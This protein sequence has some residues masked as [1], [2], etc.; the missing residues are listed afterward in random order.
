M[1]HPTLSSMLTTDLGIAEAIDQIL[2]FC[3]YIL[4]LLEKMRLD[5]SW[6]KWIGGGHTILFWCASPIGHIRCYGENFQFPY[7]DS[8]SP[9]KMGLDASWMKS[10]GEGHPT[11]SPC[12]NTILGIAAAT[13]RIR[14]W[15]HD[16]QNPLEKPFQEQ[17]QPPKSIFG[18]ISLHPTPC[19]FWANQ[20]Q[21]RCGTPRSIISLNR[22]F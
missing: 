16:I 5:T 3:F 2:N 4:D 8:E 18:L 20:A 1:G 15:D 13:G 14:S 9:W 6:M 22:R 21:Y 19:L 7:P 10:I 17:V 11:L 12:Q